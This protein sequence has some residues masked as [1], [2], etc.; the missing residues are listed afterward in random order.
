MPLLDQKNNYTLYDIDKEIARRR[1]SIDDEIGK[2]ETAEGITP[3]GI[4]SKVTPTWGEVLTKAPA[5]GL[6][7]VNVGLARDVRDIIKLADYPTR[8]AREAFGV[9]KED[10]GV[11]FL[12]SYISGQQKR[13]AELDMTGKVKDLSWYHPKKVA[14]TGLPAIP[15]VAAVAGAALMAPPTAARSAAAAALGAIAYGSAAEEAKAEGATEVQQVLHGLTSAQIEVITELPIFGAVGKLWKY[16]KAGG[17]GKKAGVSF[18]SRLLKGFGL[19]GKSMIFETGQEM[20]AYLGGQMS[21]RLH[22]DP[23]APITIEAL[24]EA[25]YGGATMSAVLFGLGAPGMAAKLATKPITKKGEIGDTTLPTTEATTLINAIDESMATGKIGATGRPFTPD[26]AIAVIKQGYDDN[27]LTDKDLENLAERYP[28]LKNGIISEKISS[29]IDQEVSEERESAARDALEVGKD[30]TAKELLTGKRGKALTSEELIRKRAETFEERRP[31]EISAETFEKEMT[32]EERVQAR[33]EIEPDINK[34]LRRA[35]E[36]GIP[37]TSKQRKE[38]KGM[39][40]EEA[41]EAAKLWNDMWQGVS[42]ENEKKARILEAQTLIRERPDIFNTQMFPPEVTEHLELPA[43]QGFEIKPKT[44]LRKTPVSKPY[45]ADVSYKP[46]LSKSGKPFK[47]M[48]WANRVLK[49]KGLNP[50]EYTIVE[51]GDGF[52]IQRFGRKIKPAPTEPKTDVAFEPEGAE[53][54]AKET[55]TTYKGEVEGLYYWDVDVGSKVPTTI[56][57]KSL[58]LE[59][60]QK[61]V[62]ETKRKFGVEKAV[63]GEKGEISKII[64]PKLEEE[65]GRFLEKVGKR[66]ESEAIGQDILD[67]LEENNIRP[68]SVSKTFWKDTFFKLPGKA[69]DNITG[70]LTSLTGMKPGDVIATLKGKEIKAKDWFD[71]AKMV[72]DDFSSIEY[73]EGTER[74]YISL[75]AYANEQI[76]IEKPAKP[77]P[78]KLPKPKP[79]EAAGEDFEGEGIGK[80]GARI[81]S[82][83]NKILNTENEVVGS[84]TLSR[85]D[86]I[87]NIDDIEVLRKGKG[88]GTKTIKDLMKSADKQGLIITLTSD[89]MRGKE[90]QKLNRLWYKKLGFTRNVG[91][92]KIK[93]TSEEFYYK[94][95]DIVEPTPKIEKEKVEVTPAKKEP[96]EMTRDEILAIEGDPLAKTLDDKLEQ[97]RE[98]QAITKRG[99]APDKRLKI[100][101]YAKIVKGLER[102][103]KEKLLAHEIAVKQAIKEGKIDSH[104]DYPDLKPEIEVTKTPEGKE[105]SKETEAEAIPEGAPKAE[106]EYYVPELDKVFKESEFI[107]TKTPMGTT[108]GL[109]ELPDKAVSHITKEDT[110]KPSPAIKPEVYA[111]ARR[112]FGIAEIKPKAEKPTPAK[113]ETFAGKKKITA[114][115]RIG[116]GQIIGVGQPE[117]K[118]GTNVPAAVEYDSTSKMWAIRPND[119]TVSFGLYK[120]SDKAKQA[121]EKQRQGEVEIKAIPEG[122]EIS[123][124]LTKKEEVALTPKE[125]KAYL[126]AEIDKAIETE[127]KTEG[128]EGGIDEARGQ[129]KRRIN[130]L[131]QSKTSYKFEVPNDGT[132]EIAGSALFEFQDRVKSAFPS[133]ITSKKFKPTKPAKKAVP[134]A[135]YNKIIGVS[136]EKLKP[137]DI[138]RIFKEV[139]DTEARDATGAIQLNPFQNWL[140]SQNI[141]KAVQD[142]IKSVAGKDY[143]EEARVKIET[144]DIGYAESMIEYTRGEFE[145]L[146]SLYDE[147]KSGEKT[148]KQINKETETKRSGRELA[149]ETDDAKSA[150]YK[151]V[152][153]LEELQKPKEGEKKFATKATK[154]QDTITRKDLKEIFS[155]MKNVMTGQDKDGNFYFKTVGRPKVTIYEVDHI[156][157]YI[158]TSSGQIPVG[159][160]LKDTIELKT[161]GKGHTADIGTAWHEF[162]HWMIKNGILSSN[163]LQAINRAIVETKGIRESAITEENQADYVGDNLA[164]W[165]GQKNLRIRRIL[166]KVRQFMDAIYDFAAKAGWVAEREK[167][168]ERVLGEIES[169]KI[170]SEKEL[171]G[172]NEFAQAVSFSL[173]KAVSAIRSNPNFNKWF[174]KSAVVDENE[175]P[176]PVHHGTPDLPFTVFRHQAKQLGQIWGRGFYFTKSIEDAKRWSKLGLK[177]YGE[178]SVISAYLSIQ[179]PIVLKGDSVDANIFE[180]LPNDFREELLEKLKDYD[181]QPM[182]DAVSGEYIEDF[183]V[184]KL[185]QEITFYAKELGY[186]GV[187]GTYDNNEHFMPF[188]S[189]QIKSIFNTGAYGL[190][191]PNIMYQMAGEKAIGADKG[192]LAKSQKMLAEGKDKKEVW[193]ETGWLKGIEGKYRFEIDDSGATIKQPEIKRDKYGFLPKDFT[194]DEIM[195]HEKLF[196]AYP[197]LRKTTIKET[198][199]HQ[200]LGFDFGQYDHST[201]TIFITK[202]TSIQEKA[203]YKEIID[204]RILSTLFHEIQH[205]I[206]KIEGFARG[207]SPKLLAQTKVNKFE[208]M[209]EARHFYSA[210]AENLKDNARIVKSDINDNYKV[211]VDPPFGYDA[212][213]EYKKLAGEIEA[214]DTSARAK[215]T[216]KQRREQMPYES[217]GIPHE[218]WM[219]TDGKG[220]SFSVEETKKFATK[221]SIDYKELIREYQKAQKKP[222]GKDTPAFSKF[223]KQVLPGFKSN[224][225]KLKYG[226]DNSRSDEGAFDLSETSTLFET[227][228]YNIVNWLDPQKKI[229]KAIEDTTGTIPEYADVLTTEMLRISKTKAD[230]NKAERQHY[231]PIKKLIGAFNLTVDI[232]DEFLYAR[233]AQEANARLRL[234]NAKMQ[235]K[236]LNELRKDNRLTAEI[237]RIDDLFE[238]S[239]FSIKQDQY[240]KLLERELQYTKSEKEI[241][242][243]KK[244]EHFKSKPS[245]MTDAEAQKIVLKYKNH[246]VLN[247]I[248]NRFDIMNNEKLDILLESGRLSQKEYDAI[249]G[250]FQYYAPLKR[251]GLESRPKVGR[252]I[253]VLMKDIKVRGGSTKRAVNILANAM[254]DLDSALIKKRKSESARALLELVRLNPNENVWRI[255]TPRTTP[256]YDT[257]GNIVLYND[258]TV[259]DNELKIKVD[260]DLYL[261]SALNEHSF[262]VIKGLRGDNY[263]S[264]PI[265]NALGRLNRYLAMI[266]TS[267]SPEFMI[268]NFARDTQTAFYNLSSTEIDHV[269]TRVIKD[270]PK[271]MKGLKNYLRGEGTHE[272]AKH[273]KQFEESGAKIGWIDFAGTISERA[274]KLEKEI[275]LFRDGHVTKKSLHK[276]GKFIE[277]YNTIVENAVRLSTFKNAVEQ[278]IPVRKAALMAKD[279]TVNFNQKGIYGTLFNSLY[280]FSNAGIQ[281]SAKVLS[282]LKNSPKA[283]KMVFTSMVAATGLAIANSGL[284]GD[285]DDGVPYYDKIEDYV[286]ERNMIIMLPGTKGKYA[287]IPLPWGYN[288]FWALGTEVG[289]MVTQKDYTVT[290][291]IS[292]MISTITGAFNPLQSSTLLQMLSPTVTDP[293]VQIAENK[294]WSGNP[295]MPENSPFSDVEKP[296]SELYWASARRP[297]KL[298]ARSLNYISGGNQIRPGLMDV[299]PETLDLVWDTFTGSAGK[300]AM[301]TLNLPLT[302]T[303]P[304]VR[305]RKIPIVRR[306][307]GQKSEY[308]DSAKFRENIAHVYLLRDEIEAYPKRERDIKKDKTYRLLK[309][310]K[311]AESSI[312]KE[313]KELKKAITQKAK[314]RIKKR[315]QTTQQRFNKRFLDRL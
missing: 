80:V 208:T 172:I 290:G 306:L 13:Q 123:V 66:L 97:V 118:T 146:Q 10:P 206:Q 304:D 222:I 199:A 142:K 60:L 86:N 105:I 73:L 307:A 269:K 119:E 14:A 39:T 99:R 5:S 167:T 32:E 216:A 286:K 315:I 301:D 305:L 132:F 239:P 6:A 203:P 155:K 265:V 242:F 45:E 164:V 263:Q 271:A 202:P 313:N 1:K 258:M 246:R 273:A 20:E 211:Y 282:V 83:T 243:K 214:R 81:E 247:K 122:K 98:R 283:R 215:L 76:K 228:K 91:K 188:K 137:A 250:T 69:Q 210:L 264:G 204:D 174:K 4:T 229:Q 194:L 252:G 221:P 275:D 71:I 249:K 113:K 114:G 248:A 111:K 274:R 235:L 224:K 154:P 133:T 311:E 124:D 287:K 276:L 65:Y 139:A 49:S 226:Y 125:Q 35:P 298:M 255:E 219:I 192:A 253:Q 217:Q 72:E 173:K 8:V 268:N 53:Q 77:Q 207:G 55:N 261:I 251:E 279:L 101:S 165:Q 26:L 89:A 117:M 244:W 42:S 31:A 54:I 257:G 231:K 159:S 166:R 260:G 2:R 9:E 23:D 29:E 153:H 201:N 112:A 225:Q 30:V 238:K 57:T 121:L 291:G 227:F 85:K 299:S 96:R 300:F 92:D 150:Y 288:V 94:T 184:E 51:H 209:E 256:G 259:Q 197:Q 44:K 262:R 11:K 152:K 157:G 120:T 116:G 177:Q 187:I 59:E 46:I 134:T 109:K 33:A 18:I 115:K 100:D 176:L 281:G 38:L 25:G 230:R 151:A 74:G 236:R 158:N 240:Y 27:V 183:E 102:Q 285:D 138:D 175:K 195:N 309:S 170:L 47:S 205:A 79:S 136:P 292:R 245:G 62:S 280:L 293:F 43:G 296:D 68:A 254:A 104:P 22:Y 56:T 34:F 312:R 297:S 110:L 37:A 161:G 277:D 88:T 310:A 82:G 196:E 284:G 21:K 295:L 107:K 128:F 149:Q 126:M 218:D 237:K 108:W 93:E 58:D 140:L 129:L 162:T 156:E 52:A 127:L 130:P 190:T 106:K 148:L 181:D 28:E 270:I 294:T 41:Q 48:A 212:F 234:T 178:P 36:T 17:V 16:L 186:D 223:V 168:A 308:A 15:Q 78:P 289:D 189:T 272:W 191:E 171:S 200:R 267:L 50:T 314:D 182:V 185:A 64:K 75:M 7:G 24:K 266:N 232:V 131:I 61:K 19:F 95:K 87:V 303:E 144:Q 147:Y 302:L 63:A 278:G 179:K 169:G 198:P 103:I 67:N 180:L 233:H 141:S 12:E 70:Y 143:I 135:K 241:E 213:K 40:K 193:R 220:T 145:Y 3:K 163:D 90:S 160:F 84:I